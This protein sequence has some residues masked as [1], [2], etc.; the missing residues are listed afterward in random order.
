MA[1]DQKVGKAGIVGFDESRAPYP[2]AG[3]PAS[4]KEVPADGVF[5]DRVRAKVP[6][7]AHAPFAF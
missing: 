1:T 2:Q 4:A 5:R 7:L 3:R 6:L